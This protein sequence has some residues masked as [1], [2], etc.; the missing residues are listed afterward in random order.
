MSP[1]AAD[2]PLARMVE[3]TPTDYWNDSC[4]V[5]DLA[6]AVERGATGATSNPVIVGEVM[7]R[8]SSHWVPRVRE[9]AEEHP[10]WSEIELTWALIEEMGVRGAGILAPVF[11]REDGRKGRQ[12]LQT[13]P[14]NHRDAA[15]MV[16]QAVHFDTPRAEHPG[17]VPDDGRGPPGDRGGDRAWRGHQ[18]D[19]RVH[20]APGDRGRR[21]GRPWPRAVRGGGRR[22]QPVQ[23]GV[24]A[25]DRADSTTG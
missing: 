7:Q 3:T 17:Q 5:D 16:E 10:T 1:S 25:D 6:Y 24:L 12:S 2:S 4:A 19:G 8:E 9:L 11:E 14:A 15:R 20:G 23:P 18:R 22:H 21:G 13:N